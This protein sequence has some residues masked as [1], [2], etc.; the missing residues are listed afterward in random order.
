MGKVGGWVTD[1]KAGSYCQI[2]LDNGEK[3]IV[4]HDKGRFN[5]GRLTVERLKF[6]GFSSERI[7]ACNLDSEEGEKA[8][9]LLTRD[10]TQ[11][12]IDA[13]PLGAFVKHLK[14]SR[15]VDEVKSRCASLMAA[16]EQ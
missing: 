2:K 11:R 9:A 15:S 7:F 14:T 13:T 12:S 6:L 10:A 5:G 16:V 4:N 1:P 3:V 8:I